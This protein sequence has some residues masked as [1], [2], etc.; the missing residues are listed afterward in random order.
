MPS[1]LPLAPYLFDQ[2][3]IAYRWSPQ[4]VERFEPGELCNRE[5][6]VDPRATCSVTLIRV[7][8]FAHGWSDSFSLVERGAP[9]DVRLFL[10]D[11]GKP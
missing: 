9:P 4:R 2:S 1:S 3:F 5:L 8:I 6:E 7:S 11:K 10:V